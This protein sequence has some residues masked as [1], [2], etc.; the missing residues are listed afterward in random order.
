MTKEN[1]KNLVKKNWK[2]YCGVIGIAGVT[3]GSFILGRR[4]FPKVNEDNIYQTLCNWHINRSDGTSDRLTFGEAL[5]VGSA[6]DYIFKKIV[7]EKL[8]GGDIIDG[9]IDEWAK[10]APESDEILW[11]LGYW[12]TEE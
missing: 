4:C 11:R 9:F 1:I 5:A 2:T 8:V 12:K 10:E 3:I 6:T 7:D